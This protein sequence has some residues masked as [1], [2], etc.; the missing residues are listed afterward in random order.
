MNFFLF[1]R[2][3]FFF[4]DARDPAVRIAQ[5]AAVSGWIVEYGRQKSDVI[6]LAGGQPPQCGD[7]RQR[8][9][10][11]EHQSCGAG[12]Q[13]R[14]CLLPS[15]SRAQLLRLADEGEVGSV[16]CHGHLLPP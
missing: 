3:I 16:H 8:N 12:I 13:L 10:A 4:D 9:I 7:R 1:W 15:V 5:D 11:V 6:A 2:R 14:Q